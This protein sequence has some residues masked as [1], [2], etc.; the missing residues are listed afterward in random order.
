MMPCGGKKERR[1]LK[2]QRRDEL[3]NAQR[4]RTS[5]FI[6]CDINHWTPRLAGAAWS[7]SDDEKNHRQGG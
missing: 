6:R 4:L 1:L 7:R 3:E 5:A 2:Q